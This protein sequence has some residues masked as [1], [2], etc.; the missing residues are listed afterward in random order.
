MARME[1]GG[2]KGGDGCCGKRDG[3]VRKDVCLCVYMPMCVCACRTFLQQELLL[4]LLP[5]QAGGSFSSTSY[6]RKGKKETREI[7]LPL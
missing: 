3:P 1:Q 2:N 5:T 7:I 4:R 6:S